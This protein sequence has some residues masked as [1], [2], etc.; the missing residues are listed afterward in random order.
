[1]WLG[2]GGGYL[3][4]RQQLLEDLVKRLESVEGDNSNLNQRLDT[5]SMIFGQVK[6]RIR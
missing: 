5:E 6:M 4:F 2:V 1:M 3:V